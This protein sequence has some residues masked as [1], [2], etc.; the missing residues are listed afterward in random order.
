MMFGTYENPIEWRHT[1]GFDEE[2]EQQLLK[3]LRYR[4]VH[5]SEPGLGTEPKK[6]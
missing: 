2:K 4:D 1:C 5:K 3:M 6:R